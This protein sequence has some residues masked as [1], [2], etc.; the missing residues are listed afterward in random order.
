MNRRLRLAAAACVALG[1]A[2][3]MSN[4]WLGHQIEQAHQRQLERV[5]TVVGPDKLVSNTYDRGL[6]SSTANL[7]LQLKVPAP[8]LSMPDKNRRKNMSWADES[9][10]DPAEALAQDTADLPAEDAD[11]DETTDIASDA[12]IDP[13][14]RDRTLRVHLVQKLDHGPLTVG[15]WAA[16]AVETRLLRV[17]GLEPEAYQLFADLEPPVLNT[18]HGF[19][20]AVGGQFTLPAGEIKDPSDPSGKN[21]LQWEALRYDFDIDADRSRIRGKGQWP[22]LAGTLSQPGGPAQLTLTMKDLAIQSEHQLNTGQWLMPP[23]QHEGSLSRF[24]IKLDDKLAPMHVLLNDVR[25]ES[26]AHQTEGVLAMKQQISGE[27]E[28]GPL[29]FEKLNMESE[30]QRVDARVLAELQQ[31]MITAIKTASTSDDAPKAPD[32]E[33]LFNRLLAASPELKERISLTTEGETAVIAY[34]FKVDPSI[35]PSADDLP[36]ALANAERLKGSASV[37]LPRD[38]LKTIAESLDHPQMS[39]DQALALMDT[40]AAQGYLKPTDT[41]WTTEA[42]FMKG[43]LT[44]NGKPIFD[45][46][47]LGLIGRS[48]LP[49]DSPDDETEE[50][51]ALG[52]APDVE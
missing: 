13:F 4:W 38:F 11:M 27:A 19:S 36:P 12:G 9:A 44:V 21:R 48:P 39:A 20:Q 1:G 8:S 30:I 17:D 46:Y 34:G 47:G 18:V 49:D 42:E 35:M 41:G 32:F 37:L 25:T 31:L 29:S 33:Q 28:F 6:F 14:Q 51:D 16:A 2:Y 52:D 22:L 50:E 7:V 5:L 23:G 10:H 40:V 3:V 15:G 24:E 45:N 26:Q 43:S